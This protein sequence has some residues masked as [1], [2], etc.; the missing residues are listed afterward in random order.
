M[1]AEKIITL[2]TKLNELNLGIWLHWQEYDGSELLNSGHQYFFIP[3]SHVNANGPGVYIPM[4]TGV[5]KTIGT[6]NDI[7]KYLYITNNTVQGHD[8]NA[9]SSDSGGVGTKRYVLS[10]IVG[11]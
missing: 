4:F 7:K 10:G 1:D 6:S 9:L 3:K 8:S 11:F 2:P 5:G